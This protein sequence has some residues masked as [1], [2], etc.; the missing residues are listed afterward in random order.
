MHRGSR[1]FRQVHNTH[2]HKDDPYNDGDNSKQMNDAY[3]LAVI[4][5]LS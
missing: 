1:R 2:Q 5:R 4:G 3:Y